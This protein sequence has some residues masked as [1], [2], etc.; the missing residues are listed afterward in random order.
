MIEPL[1][2]Q[3]IQDIRQVAGQLGVES[4]S[5]GQYVQ[6]G[7]FTYYQVWDE[8]RTWT[9]LCRAAGVKTKEKEPVPDEVYFHNLSRA[10]QELGRYPKVSERK[11]YQLN[12]KKRRWPTLTAFITKAI[13]LGFV[14]NLKGDR[15]RDESSN[16]PDTQGHPLGIRHYGN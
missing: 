9:E 16:C 3:I 11:K 8:G 2:E 14:P 7:R 1:E 5:C 6:S 15:G 12:F 13:E 10:V 4:L